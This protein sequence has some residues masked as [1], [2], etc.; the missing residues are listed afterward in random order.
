MSAMLNL[1]LKGNKWYTYSV[2]ITTEHNNITGARTITF[3]PGDKFYSLQDLIE[4]TLD[5][6][7]DAPII[8]KYLDEVLLLSKGNKG[9]K[10]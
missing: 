5:L 1:Q 2:I 7:E 6:M 8:S 9:D 3:I 10:M 4:S